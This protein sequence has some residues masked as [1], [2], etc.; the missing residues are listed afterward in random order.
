MQTIYLDNAATTKPNSEALEFAINKLADD[1]FYNPS[2]LY[3]RARRVS[4]EVDA[5]RKQILSFF[6]KG[7]NLT[8]T[9]CGSESDNTAIFSFAKRG[10]VVTTLGEH[11]AVYNTFNEVKQR[12]VEVRFAP[13]NKN[14]SVNEE[15]LLSL[16]DDKTTFVSIVHVNNETGAINDI[17]RL[18]KLIKQKN[19]NVIFHSDG[20]QAFLK[21]DYKMSSEVD[22]YS[23]SSHKFC[24]L[25]GC[26]CL[27]YKAN[28][29]IKP[30]IFG[31]GQE[32][33]TRSGTENTLDI[34]VMQKACQLYSNVQA[35]LKKV[36]QL[37]QAFISSIQEVATIISDENCS[38]YIVSF[39]IEGTKGEIMQRMLEDKNVIV[40]T[41]SA[42]SS[43]LGTSRII[44][45]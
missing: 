26:G 43:K 21:I 32:K 20:V 7:Y 3:S 19:K 33:G 38:P 36:E 31:G 34:F 28:L 12:G 27:I 35:N 1:G 4:V 2:A 6:P 10:N 11:S 14:G 39:S 24:A 41:G 37:K 29:H 30:L 42:C 5:A 18:A 13:L 9:S 44:S 25:K 40:G 22:L 15:K 23:I 16:I 17:N 8:F 45:N